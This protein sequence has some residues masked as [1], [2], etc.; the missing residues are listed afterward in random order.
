[1]EVFSYNDYIK[2]IH[3]LRLN[4]V[5]RLAE[6]GTEYNLEIDK[7]KK[8]IKNVHDKIIK[9]I[10]KNRNEVANIINDFVGIREKIKGENLVKYTNSFV[11]GKYK[12]REA[13]IVY[14]L[15]DKDIFFLIEHQSSVDN[16][17][18]YRMLDYCID[19]IY[20]WST[21]IKI[22]KGIKYPIVV[23]IVIYTGTDKWRVSTDFSKMQ[24]SDYIFQNYKIDFK[25]NLIEINKI[26]FKYLIEKK[27]LFSH[28]MA[29]EKTRDYEDFK[30]I[31][32]KILIVSNKDK[33]VQEELYNISSLLLENLMKDGYSEEFLDEIYFK[34]EGGRSI[35]P[36]L[37][38]RQVQGFRKDI[39]KWVDEYIQ[40]GKEEGKEEGE[41]NSIK[42][43]VKNLID[44]NS[45]DEFIMK[46]TNITKN[47]LE[48]YKKELLVNN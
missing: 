41:R 44:N 31:L 40:E 20:D 14:R 16:N 25:Y 26:S 38:E 47:E 32:N 2:C 18:A 43:V 4:A 8:K 7:Q 42:K 37:Y 10:L 19:I 17:M 35:M 33:E 34:I 36:S 15:K 48:K 23:P 11:T 39:R 12:S 6:E 1:M 9:K 21:S 22:K 29:L 28:A 13:D 3:T 24:I 5:F 46:I 27:T 30:E 45:S